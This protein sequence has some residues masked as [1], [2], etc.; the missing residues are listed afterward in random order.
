MKKIWGIAAVLLLAAVLTACGGGGDKE[1]GS[2]STDAEPTQELKIEA[3]NWKFD[4]DSYTIKA[5][6][7]VKVSLVNAEGFHGVE[8]VGIGK[9]QAGKD[10][11]FTLEAGEYDIICSIQCGTGHNDMKSKLVVQ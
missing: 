1:S 2:A 4:A 10:Q 9:V 11:V 8:I 3:S 6:E 7:P 5:G